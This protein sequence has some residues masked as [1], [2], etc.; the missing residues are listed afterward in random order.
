MDSFTT[1][2]FTF[3]DESN[4]FDLSP[5]TPAAVP[6]SAASASGPSSPS[7]FADGSSAGEEATSGVPVDAERY[8][9]YGSFCV[10]A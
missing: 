3:S 6:V 9:G 10:I 2:L 5:I 4:S 1:F 7:L 8:Y